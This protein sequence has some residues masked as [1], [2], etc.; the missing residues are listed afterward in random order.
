[1]PLHWISQRTKAS[2]LTPLPHRHK[3]QRP[4]WAAV[5]LLRCT[6][7]AGATGGSTRAGAQIFLDARG[8]ALQ[9]AQVVELGAADIATTLHFDRVDGVR[10]GLEHALDAEAMR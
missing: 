10:V 4:R 9:I 8:L 6:G 3:R 5:G 7:R 2:R 1:M